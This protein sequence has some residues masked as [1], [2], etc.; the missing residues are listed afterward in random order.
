MAASYIDAM[1]L[2]QPNGPYYLCG[3]SFG[4]VVA[5]EMAR[6]L[7]AGS[8]EVRFLGLLDSHGG[9]YPKRR[10]SL[11]PR[12][13]LKLALLPFLPHSEWYSF[14]LALFKSGFRQWME[15]WFVRRMI[16]LDGLMKGRA[17]R[18]P[19]KSRTLYI[20]EV[21]FAARQRYKL[22]P[23]SGK[24]DLFKAE[25]QPPYQPP[26]DLFEEDPLLG[27]SG[28][29]ACG[30]EV[31]QLPGRHGMYLW[32]PAIAAVLAEKLRAC[33]EQASGKGR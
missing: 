9:E 17:L 5:F 30:I 29:A 6:R 15:R 31:H 19:F 11:T 24:I 13:R 23:F 28:M 27:W 25:N 2:H 14:A 18:C 12:K 16:A 3:S 21:C 4:G 32:E 1:R 7:V 33:L 8:E 26:S 20:Q 10:K 22:M